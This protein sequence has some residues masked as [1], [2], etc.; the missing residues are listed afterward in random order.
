V[1]NEVANMCLVIFLEQ[2]KDEEEKSARE[3]V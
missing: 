3:E 2:I 1:A